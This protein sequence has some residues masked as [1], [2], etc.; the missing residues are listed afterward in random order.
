MDRLTL[1]AIIASAAFLVFLIVTLSWHNDELRPRIWRLNEILEQDPM[2]ASYPYRFRALV[3]LNGTVTLS[4]P[5]ALE[6]PLRPFL[7]RIEPALTGKPDNA[8]EVQDAE[9]RFRSVE[10]H[11]VEMMM[12]EPDVQTVNWALDRAWYHQNG[13]ELPPPPPLSPVAR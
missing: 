6:R 13:I 7:D 4:S 11:A 3:F 5:H 9:R 2:L 8:P 12:N 10:A 1:S